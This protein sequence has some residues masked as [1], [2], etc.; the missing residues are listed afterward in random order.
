V[1]LAAVWT[2]F[3]VEEKA[4]VEPLHYAPFRRAFAARSDLSRKFGLSFPSGWA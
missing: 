3:T 4:T 2:R 1:D